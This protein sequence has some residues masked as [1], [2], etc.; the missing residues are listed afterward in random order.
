MEKESPFYAR[1]D[2]SG[3]FQVCVKIERTVGSFGVW[4]GDNPFQFMVPV[5][6]C[7]IIVT[8]LVS[9]VIYYL[10]RPIK[11]PKFICYVMGG[12]L[13]GPTGLGRIRNGALM[14]ILFPLKQASFLVSMSKIGAIYFVFIITLRMDLKMNLKAAKRCW[15]FGVIPFFCSYFV[16]V[17]LLS[18]YKPK[19]H[20]SGDDA[21]YIP[22]VFTISSF[23]V[24]CS[25]LTELNL[26]TT[27]LGQIALSSA[28]V[29][30]IM[31]WTMIGLELS[32]PK[33]L[34][35]SFVYLS[36][37]GLF[38]LICVFIVR[39]VMKIIV[40]RTPMGK[41]IKEIY[42]IMILLGVPIMSAL[43]D[44]IGL[45]FIIG[46]TLYGLV[47]PNG[48]PLAST[49]LERSE[50]I[51][52]E[53]LMPFFYLYIG[54]NTDLSEIHKHK[55]WKVALIFQGILF[56]GF[57]VK[58]LACVLLAPT[59]N[60]RLKHGL[61]L[62]LMLSVRGIVELMFFARIKKFGIIDT[63]VFSQM[64]LYVVFITMICI[65]LID[66]LYKH[67]P[68]MLKT[69]SIHEVRVRMIQNS[70]ET[71]E[72]NIVSCVHNDGNVHSM[73]ALLEACNPT[74]TSPINV[75]V[76]LLIELLGKSTPILL[77]M[78]KRNRKSF[79]ANYPNTN[80][81]LRAFENYSNNSNGPVTIIPYVN[82][83]PY[84]IMHDATCDLAEDKSVRLLI[85]PFHE[86]DETLGS[87]I[88]TSIRDLNTSFQAR[89]RC[90]VGILVDRDSRLSMSSSK[91]CFHLG[92]FFMGGQDDREAL[93]LAIRMLERPNMRVTLLRFVL[94]N[95]NKNSGG[96]VKFKGNEQEEKLES[97]MD[98]SL[99]DEFKAKKIN[100]DNVF[101]QEDVVGDCIQVF[102]AIRGSENDYDLVL[103]GKRHNIGDVTDEEMSTFMDNAVQLGIFGDFLASTE[104]CDGKVPVLV[105]QCPP[106]IY[107]DF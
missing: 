56:V 49:I 26:L 27:E 15:R 79:S 64:V 96:A 33:N 40:E 23:A 87:H 83:A 59:S 85:I 63:E 90:T 78:K 86:N 48:P 60:I 7:Q 99:I 72:F 100:N 11:T 104:F 84:N 35:Y 41:P 34:I 29:N 5:T 25:A 10:L 74:L 71:S 42:V 70:P 102:N 28:M 1:N 69:K 95:N 62:G 22:N 3:A 9:Q 55:H 76:I 91:L 45:H 19:G 51:I 105:M 2:S 46:P 47:M 66:S 39:P 73:I 82:V 57:L 107:L 67:H 30:E 52:S 17:F 13:L 101:C 44:M 14:D 54:L 50:V 80:H 97:N 77:P 37:C 31:Q 8:V 94:N 24:V 43:S 68:R 58:V 12:T 18:L 89:A 103:V 53:F 16:T 75:Y 65:A 32:P 92:I 81:I 21:Y 4:A 36:L 20:S 6:L 98:E 106:Y 38:V 93:A 88:V 61:V